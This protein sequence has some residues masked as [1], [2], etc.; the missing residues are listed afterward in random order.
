MTKE[1]EQLKGV[2]NRGC[3]Y[4]GV[5]PNAFRLSFCFGPRCKLLDLLVG[6]AGLEPATRDYEAPKSA[7]FGSIT[8]CYKTL[9]PNTDAGFK[10]SPPSP[11]CYPLLSKCALFLLSMGTKM[12]TVFFTRFSSTFSWSL[13]R[14]GPLF[15]DRKWNRVNLAQEGRRVNDS[16]NS[17]P[18]PA[19]AAAAKAEKRIILSMG[20]KWRRGKDRG[21]DR[22]GRMVRRKSD[23]G[24]TAGSRYRKEGSSLVHDGSNELAHFQPDLVVCIE[25]PSKPAADEHNRWRTLAFDEHQNRVRAGIDHLRAGIQK[26]RNRCHHNPEQSGAT[27]D[28]STSFPCLSRFARHGSARSR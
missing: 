2:Q 15:W 9:Q 7:F 25:W 8:E 26:A 12:G 3:C 28:R 13:A 1:R 6:P 10:R 19:G 18:E 20:G 4:P 23:P 27:D 21:H 14:K 16:R 5:T 24:E 17:G 22:S 11:A